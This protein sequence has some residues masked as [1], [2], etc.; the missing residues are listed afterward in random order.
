MNVK[1]YIKWKGKELRCLCKVGNEACDR[2][3]SCNKVEVTLNQYKGWEECFKNSERR[4]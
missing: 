4:R 3:K 2:Y 1:C